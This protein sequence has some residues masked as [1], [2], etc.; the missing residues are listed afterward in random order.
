MRLALARTDGRTDGRHSKV[1][2]GRAGR[3]IYCNVVFVESLESVAE[4]RWTKI[5]LGVR[6]LPISRLRRRAAPTAIIS[7][8]VKTAKN[9]PRVRC[10]YA[11][12]NLLSSRPT[13]LSALLPDLTTPSRHTW[14]FDV[15]LIWAR[16]MEP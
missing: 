3:A 10:Q 6:S 11:L 16:S 14:L 8:T 7:Q 9:V 2:A 13:A 4:S 15:T 1:P 5:R 12:S